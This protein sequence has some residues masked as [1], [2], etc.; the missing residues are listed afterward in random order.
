MLA[1]ELR[2]RLCP[3][4]IGHTLLAGTAY[5]ALVWILCLTTR[6]VYAAVRGA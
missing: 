5:M 2:G 1:Q 4:E 6:S 3:D